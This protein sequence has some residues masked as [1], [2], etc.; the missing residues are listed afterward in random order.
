[1]ISNS[2]VLF[3]VVL[4]TFLEIIYPVLLGFQVRTG[5]HRRN[6]VTTFSGFDKYKH[7]LGQM[8][9]SH[10]LQMAVVL[11]QVTQP[12]GQNNLGI[13][14]VVVLYQRLQSVASYTGHI[15][16]CPD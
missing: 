14:E 7:D 11:V 1:V 13:V 16:H 8:K 6:K 12:F 3:E 4:I 5:A 2:F 15:Q 9:Q 10:M